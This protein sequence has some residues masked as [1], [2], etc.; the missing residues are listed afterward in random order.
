MGESVS[1]GWIS[2]G[3]LSLGR[4]SVPPT[5]IVPAGGAGLLFFFESELSASRLAIA[6]A[7]FFSA[8]ASLA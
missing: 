6:S 4:L 5:G 8:A 1:L 3:G 2:F 7:F